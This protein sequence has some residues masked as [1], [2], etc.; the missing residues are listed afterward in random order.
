MQ[1]PSPQ[2]VT[3]V[4]FFY[5]QCTLLTPAIPIARY[6]HNYHTQTIDGSARVAILVFDTPAAAKKV[7]KKLDQHTIHG[8]KLSLR[9]F[10]PGDKNAATVSSAGDGE[11]GVSRT[12]SDISQMRGQAKRNNRLIIRN[13]SFKATEDDLKVNSSPSFSRLLVGVIG[14]VPPSFFP[15]TLFHV[16]RMPCPPLGRSWKPVSRR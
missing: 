9:P 15:T 7:Q 16:Y 3:P 14:S 2:F 13:L 4:P 6:P 10:H 8:Q 12:V 5:P 11:V 1:I